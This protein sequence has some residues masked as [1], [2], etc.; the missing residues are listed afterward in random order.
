MEE[1]NFKKKLS[2]KSI[3]IIC[4]IIALAIIIPVTISFYK[5]KKDYSM[6]LQQ[7]NKYMLCDDLQNAKKYYNNALNAEKTSEVSDKIDLCSKLINSKENYANALKQ[8]NNKDYLDAYAAFNNILKDDKKRYSD[9]QTKMQEC[10]KGI[11][12]EYLSDAKENAKNNDYDKALLNLDTALGYD[13]NNKEAVQLKVQ[14]EDAQKKQAQIAAQKQAEADAKA[15]A[16]QDAKDAKALADAKA[17][18]APQKI[19]DSNGK[20][21]WKVYISSGE[22][23]FTGTYKGTGNFIVKLSDSNQEMI[24]LI[25]NE[26]GDYVSDKTIPVP[27]IGWYYLEVNGSDGE[28]N[29]QWK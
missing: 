23:H 7:G 27:Y 11:V 13:H 26:I 14:Y 6:Y 29:Y 20:Q 5:N 2:I 12:T 25:A 15:K 17:K 4:I 24:D 18:Y 3:V 19:V 22:L 21:I 10:S 1:N 9:A 28:W 8:Y 16:E